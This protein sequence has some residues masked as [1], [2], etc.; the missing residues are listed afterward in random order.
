MH[1]LQCEL[2]SIWFDK[3]RCNDAEVAHQMRLAG[4]AAP[5]AVKAASPAKQAAPCKAKPAAAAASPLVSEIAA[6][7][8]KIH[9]ELDRKSLSG[10]ESELVVRIEK[11]EV[12][13]QALRSGAA[14]LTALVKALELRVAALE[15]KPAAAAAKPAAAAPVKQEAP[16]KEESDDDDDDLFGSDDEEED[17]AAAKLKEERLAAYAAKKAAKPAL[18][19]K[20]SILLDVKPWDDETDMKEMEKAV[21]S[22]QTDGLLW[23]ASKLVP[24]AYGIKKLQIMCTVEDDKVGTDFLEEKI[25]EFE[26]LVQS[27]DVAAFNKI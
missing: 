13:N 7:R 9:T 2:S 10:G 11:L 22:V 16:K 12:E 17:E 24:L 4:V 8:K 18:I 5:A 15:G 6:A 1:P 3:Y 21:R 14:E 26:D 23:G 27:V 20:S 19:A 25:T